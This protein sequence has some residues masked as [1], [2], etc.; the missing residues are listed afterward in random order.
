MDNNN[1]TLPASARH[2]FPPEKPKLQGRTELRI[3]QRITAKYSKV[4]PNVLLSVLNS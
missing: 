3:H 4:V 1:Q 2:I